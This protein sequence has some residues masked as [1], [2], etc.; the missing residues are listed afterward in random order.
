[1][2]VIDDNSNS[3]DHSK[4][5]VETWK[6][7][8]P[9]IN[10]KTFDTQEKN[11]GPGGA[12]N[13]GLDN[14]QGNYILFLDSDDELNDNA[15]ASIQKA[16]NDNPSTDIFVLGYQMTRLDFSE[17]KVNTMNLPASKLQ[18]SRLYQIGVNTAGSIWNTCIKKS[19]FD[20]KNGRD[21]IRFKSNCV[22]EDLPTKVQLFTRNKQ[23]IKSIKNITHTQFSRPCKS[24]TGSLNFKDMKRL[25]E[26]NKE[27]ANLKP[28]A[29]RKDKMYIDIRLAMLP[30]LLS[31]FTVKCIHNKIDRYKMKLSEKE[32]EESR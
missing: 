13:I 30:A 17:N 29:D 27:I 32:K 3:D 14:A 7:Q 20:G 4:M 19:L 21:K 28:N 12:R 23:K 2:L 15:L 18:E 25:I 31:W 16:I 6:Q 9:F 10:V 8:Y 26:A 1:M 11:R 24:I 22:F 5:F